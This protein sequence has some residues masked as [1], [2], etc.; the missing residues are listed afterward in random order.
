[1]LFQTTRNDIRARY[2]GS[3]LGLIWMVLY[4]V[5]FLGAYVFMFI[6]IGQLKSLRGAQDQVTIIRIFCWLIPFIGFSE[7]LGAGVTAVS[8]NA[9]LIKNTLFP[10][11]LMPVRVVLSSQCTQVVGSGLLLIALALYHKLTFWA[12][13]LPAVWFCQVMF[14]FG[15][16]WIV[17]SLNVYFRDLQS[18]VGLL[19]FIL[20]MVSPIF[21]TPDMI[22]AGIRPYM[23]IN[24]L[25]YI[26][27]SHQECLLFGRFPHYGVF[28]GLMLMAAGS[29]L[30]G[31]WF[32]RRMKR[33][34]ADNV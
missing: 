3:L 14:T 24:P 34:F 31:F 25:Y 22:P 9:N 33:V 27:I 13:L 23:C 7:A 21:W 12:L 15:L 5:L 2:A 11:E 28:W 18:I 1:M 16:I 17:S 20:M 26:I 19:I 29:F 8:T 30:V 32:F 10:I 4:P 6:A